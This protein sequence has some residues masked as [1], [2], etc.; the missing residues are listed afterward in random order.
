M[1]S[2]C[3]RRSVTL[4]AA[5]PWIAASSPGQGMSLE[6]AAKHSPGREAWLLD[7][8]DTEGFYQPMEIIKRPEGLIV[9]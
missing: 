7:T 6:E 8:V 1:L 2:G 9:K 5:K 3:N 4:A